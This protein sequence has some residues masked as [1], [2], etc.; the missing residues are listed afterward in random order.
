[1]NT[2]VNSS[3][4]GLFKLA[5]VSLLLTT[6]LLL[7]AAGISFYIG[8]TLGTFQSFLNVIGSSYMLAII[9]HALLTI[10]IGL[11]VP[12]MMA[13]FFALR[14]AST[15]KAVA[16]TGLGIAG[17][18]VFIANTGNYFWLIG[19]AQSYARNC[20]SCQPLLQQE[21]YA[22]N[23]VTFDLFTA[24]L[25]FAIAIMII[26]WTMMKTA[27]FGKSPAYLGILS[28]A[29]AIIAPLVVLSINTDPNFVLTSYPATFAL[30][31]YAVWF[32]IVATK[33]R[34]ISK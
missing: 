30:V 25:L 8:Q 29:Y 23:S 9:G 3:Y 1:M 24:Q 14:G 11:L 22:T 18:F 26:S 6:T 31:L 4:K 13:L 12:V 5:W 16:G 28:G 20:N 33:F 19:L 32:A 2:S 21:A 7:V 17:I 34:S 15:G 10:G 27:S